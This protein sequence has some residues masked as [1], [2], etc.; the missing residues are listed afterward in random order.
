MH[1]S[2][3]SQP[4]AGIDEVPERLFRGEH[5]PHRGRQ[6]PFTAQELID[7]FGRIS[8][9]EKQRPGTYRAFVFVLFAP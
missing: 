3:E 2:A 6:P 1:S 9:I 8:E 7:R 4:A 5:R